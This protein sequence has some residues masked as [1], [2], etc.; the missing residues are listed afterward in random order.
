MTL[1]RNDQTSLW[2]GL[3]LEWI[4]LILFLALLPFHLVIKSFLPQP[5]GT[6]WKE[7]LLGLLVLGWIIHC[8][9]ERRLLRTKTPLDLAVGLYLG[10][11]ILRFMLDG[12]DLTAA[13]G[14]YISGLYLPLFW[15][16][17]TILRRQPG[18]FSWLLGLL[19]AV[20]GLVALGGVIEFLVD[21]PLWPS[22]E[23]LRLQGYPDVFIY[24]TH[25]RRVYFTLDSPTTLANTLALLLPLAIVF[26][27][28]GSN[29][30][31]PVRIG[32][33]VAAGLMVLA[34]IFTFSRGI[35]FSMTVSLA[36]MVFMGGM[37]RS[38]RWQTILQNS[39]VRVAAIAVVVVLIGL[40][41]VGMLV[42]QSNRVA[43]AGKGVIEL[44]P[45]AYNNIPITEIEQSLLSTEPAKGQ[46][47]QQ[48]WTIFDPINSRDD[49]RPVLYHHPKQ[50]GR[51]EIIYRLTVPEHGAL[52]FGIA[53]APE[54]WSPAKGDGVSFEVYVTNPET[55]KEEFIFSRYIN[56][57]HNPPDRRW[58]NFLVDLSPWAGETIR[59]SLITKAGP[60]NDSAFDWAGWADPQ[61][62]NLRP[63]YFASVSSAAN[64][65]IRRHIGSVLDWTGD[66]SNRDRLMAWNRGLDAWLSAPLWGKGL[67]TTG[68][69]AL[70]T[71]PAE[72]FVTESQLLKAL[73]E[74]GLPGLAVL[75]YLWFEIGRQ[76]YR[77]Y[78]SLADP[79]QRLLLLGI[80]TG[81]LAI[82]IN[83]LVYQ[84]LE[85]KQVNAYFW[86]LVGTL[87]FMAGADTAPES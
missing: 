8:L 45:T 23:L 37:I 32:A 44:P 3:K 28:P 5:W 69:A 84:N 62:V 65:P 43:I 60:V 50:A 46:A 57:K 75:L 33:G 14:L 63:D 56:P 2:Q 54:V 17:P 25:I 26:A 74:L 19:V 59:L 68:A 47:N 12:F 82:F 40:V 21:R 48:R 72:A 71:Q 24:G 4:G 77:T 53:L 51:N 16:V 1:N 9:Q 42:W 11:L 61:L 70:R 7:I 85:A 49:S 73:V 38:A 15:L 10:L 83:G 80:L 35:W 58:R 30:P 87:A 31:R 76:G 86:T 79:R 29:R 20:G 64:K 41:V 39:K 27:L 52:R 6:Y 67:G 18:R 81:L 22:E 66:V 55:D 13:W 34:I 36:A 78:R